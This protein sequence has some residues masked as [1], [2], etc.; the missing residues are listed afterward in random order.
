MKDKASVVLISIKTNKQIVEILKSSKKLNLPYITIWLTKQPNK[1]QIQYALLVNKSQFKLAV[2]RN[3]VKRQ[4]RNILI[5]SEL[6]GGIKILLKP[7]SNY[8]KR[9][10]AQ[11]Q[12]QTIKTITRYQNGK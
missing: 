6:K 8:L 7:N 3:K 11:I 5:N 10:Y 12:E 9:S 4:L 1:S 2:A